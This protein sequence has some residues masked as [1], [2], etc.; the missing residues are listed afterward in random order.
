[1]LE[2]LQFRLP[3]SSALL[4]VHAGLLAYLLASRVCLDAPMSPHWWGCWAQ[5]PAW[6][7]F[8]VA[9]VWSGYR[10]YTAGEGLPALFWPSA[11]VGPIVYALRYRRCGQGYFWWYPHVSYLW[12]A[13]VA[14]ILTSVSDT[15]VPVVV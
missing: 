11:V 4:A 2:A 6:L 15:L 1:M 8:M 7:S 9:L 14:G 12:H 5:F 13:C 3:G 10:V